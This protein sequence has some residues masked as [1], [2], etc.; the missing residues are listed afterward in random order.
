MPKKNTKISLHN[1]EELVS[2]RKKEL[3]SN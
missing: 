1:A 2:L 3:E